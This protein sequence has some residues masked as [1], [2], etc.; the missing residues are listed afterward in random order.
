[1]RT[2]DVKGEGK[3]HTADVWR[4]V[5]RRCTPKYQARF[6]HYEGVTVCKEWLVYS[7]FKAWYESWNLCDVDID[8]DIITIGNK[9]YSPHNCCL[10][11]PRLNALMVN[12]PNTSGISLTESGKYHA[13][14]SVNGVR[15]TL[16]TFNTKQEAHKAYTVAKIV[17]IE[18][19]LPHVS[20]DIRI[21]QGL[22]NHVKAL[23]L[24]LSS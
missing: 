3:S 11:S 6:P 7:K 18:Q 1:M 20:Y 23:K 15:N 8:K 17:A 24:T 12:K 9:E 16:G 4:G 5:L 10:V 14:I 19:W 22:Q 13:R 21:Q 2:F